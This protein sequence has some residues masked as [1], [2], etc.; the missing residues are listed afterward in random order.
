MCKQPDRVQAAAASV[1]SD[2]ST[3]NRRQR[4]HS[5][6]LVGRWRRSSD[7]S[8]AAASGCAAALP[9]VVAA[10][11]VTPGS[12]GSCCRTAATV[13]HGVVADGSSC[14]T[15][16]LLHTAASGMHGLCWAA[17]SACPEQERLSSMAQC[18]TCMPA[19]QPGLHLFACLCLC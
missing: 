2:C 17:R 7:G 6:Q 16:A 8:L 19:A 11:A 12:L 13:E 14:S 10:A 9:S 4:Q 3:T 15:L 18:N 5:Q 1:C